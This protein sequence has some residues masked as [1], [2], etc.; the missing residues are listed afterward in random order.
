MLWTVLAAASAAPPPAVVAH[1]EQMVAATEQVRDATYTLVRSEWVKGK[2]VATQT[3]AIR[4]RRTEDLW[5]EW[6]DDVYPGRKVLYR[7]D[8]NAGE[9][10]ARPTRFLPLFN[11][12]PA[13][14]IAMHD[15]RHPV[16]MSALT[17][18]VSKM[19]KVM[20]VLVANPAID[21]R[22]VDEG[23][24]QEGGVPSQCYSGALPYNRHPELY[25]PKV[26]FC[27]GVDSRLPTRFQAWKAEDGAIR[28][29][30]DYEFR[31]LV[32]NPGLTD[33]HFNPAD[34]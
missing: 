7:P 31:D 25:A 26:R 11:L 24:Q 28:M 27:G 15:N 34:L 30:E 19:A 29:V 32:V 17:R 5:L 21:A 22:F 23:I 16:W 8:W 33:A 3:I 20:G 12:D 6:Q 13:G 9:L 18:I 10:H 2:Q 1:F 4:F 14:A